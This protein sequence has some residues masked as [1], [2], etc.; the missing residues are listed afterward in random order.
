MKRIIYLVCMILFFTLSSHAQ[1]RI[2][3]DSSTVF[4]DTLGNKITS[5]K[6]GQIIQASQG[7]I[8]PDPIIENGVI[9]QMGMKIL[10]KEEMGMRM[11]LSESLDA[12][13]GKKAP[14]FEGK[15][16]D[17]QRVKLS[18]LKDKVVVL[19]FWFTQCKPCL[20][21]MPELNKMVEEK[22]K[23][24]NDVV[25]IS[26]CLDDKAA[27]AKLLET[28][29]FSYRTLCNMRAVADKYNIA[30]YPTHLV[31]DKN[32]IVTQASNAGIR[33]LLE[34]AIDKALEAN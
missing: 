31:I 7:R 18:N 15:D 11:A 17:G 26:L 8:R 14:N 23:N 29:P 9:K 4:T 27:T 5:Q 33:S 10:T 1:T 28:H 24:N 22:Y 2:S 13:K 30:A 19:K 16:L 3:T 25:F 12:L 32:G 34:T 6:F 21:E 20:M